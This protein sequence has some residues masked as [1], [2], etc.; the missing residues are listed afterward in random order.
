MECPGVFTQAPLILVERRPGA[1]ERRAVM[2]DDSAVREGYA[3]APRPPH[4]Q[5]R[6]AARDERHDER[7]C[8]CRDVHQAGLHTPVRTAGVGE[9]S[10]VAPPRPH[11]LDDLIPRSNQRPPAVNPQ[12]IAQPGARALEHAGRQAVVSNTDRPQDLGYITESEQRHGFVRVPRVIDDRSTAPF[13]LRDQ[14]V[15]RRAPSD[16]GG[17]PAR[18]QPHGHHRARREDD[19]PQERPVPSDLTRHVRQR[20]PAPPGGWLLVIDTTHVWPPADRAFVS[21]G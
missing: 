17:A 6:L 14:V 10:D 15:E 11:Q 19:R 18:V 5:E 9:E 2:D 16:A 4:P 3:V 13:D 1:V 20:N 21:T 7:V 8:R 12:V